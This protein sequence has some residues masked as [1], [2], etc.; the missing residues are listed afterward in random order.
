MATA[1]E[2]VPTGDATCVQLRTRGETPLVNDDPK[3]V[4]RAQYQPPRYSFQC[5]CGSTITETL[6]K[7]TIACVCGCSYT[8][9]LVLDVK[10][11]R[12]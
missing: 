8:A 12:P 7:T 6:D 9:R 3:W 11:V 1:A 2:K 5:R 4:P 10:E